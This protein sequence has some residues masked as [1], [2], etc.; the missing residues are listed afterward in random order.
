MLEKL[1]YTKGEFAA[2]TGVSEI[3]IHRRIKAGEIHATHLGKRVLIP[4]SE[5][6]R[7]TELA[8]APIC[9]KA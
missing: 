7:F 6:T 5:A 9:E 1:F 4:T 8:M 2:I 3:T